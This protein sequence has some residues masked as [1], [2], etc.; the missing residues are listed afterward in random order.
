MPRSGMHLWPASVAWGIF[1]TQGKAP[2]ELG[3]LLIVPG[4]NF[5][6]KRRS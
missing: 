3:R 6:F 1:P 5:H 2:L 4:M